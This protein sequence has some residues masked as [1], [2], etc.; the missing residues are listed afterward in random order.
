M[1]YDDLA[2]ESVITDLDYA[3]EISK[4]FSEKHGVEF[5]GSITTAIA[6][7]KLL[8]MARADWRQHD[9]NIDLND[10]MTELTSALKNGLY[11]ISCQL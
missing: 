8:G 2:F 6:I 3:I 10:A 11:D 1:M 9:Q 5:D 4:S 7:A